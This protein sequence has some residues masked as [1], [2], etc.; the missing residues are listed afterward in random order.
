MS[1]DT[2]DLARSIAGHAMKPMKI[3]IVH[4]R[5]AGFDALADELTKLRDEW[6]NTAVSHATAIALGKP[7]PPPREARTGNNYVA[8]AAPTLLTPASD[9]NAAIYDFQAAR[10]RR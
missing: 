10:A 6:G 8:R 3:A 7:P 4:L 5:N 2:A 1:N 9:E